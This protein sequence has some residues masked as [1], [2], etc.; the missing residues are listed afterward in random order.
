MKQHVKIGLIVGVVG[1]V[2][3]SCVSLLFGLCG[4][5][6][7]IVAGIVAGFLSIHKQYGI[8][9]KEAGKLGA[10]SG[11][12]AGAVIIFGQVLAAIGSLAITQAMGLPLLFNTGYPP[13]ASDG[14]AAQISYYLVGAVTGACLGLFGLILASAAGYGTA[15]F[16]APA[17]VETIA[18]EEVEEEVIP[19][20]D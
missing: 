3:N 16:M 9:K 20:S 4:P 6:V 10:I 1:A 15:Y 19:S 8:E 18:E 13:T 17:A 7:S 12:A 14:I 11:A 2:L 5:V